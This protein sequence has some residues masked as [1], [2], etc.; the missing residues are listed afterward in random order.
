VL[1]YHKT[2]VLRDIVPFA[3]AIYPRRDLFSYNNV[4]TLT[5]PP[6]SSWGQ[7]SFKETVYERPIRDHFKDFLNAGKQ[8]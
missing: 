1:L 2:N 5:P 8:P 7:H 3:N 6:G 4:I